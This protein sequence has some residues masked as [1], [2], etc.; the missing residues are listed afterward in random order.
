[1]AK[2]KPCPQRDKEIHSY[3]STRDTGRRRGFVR[4]VRHPAHRVCRGRD[5]D[6]RAAVAAHL[7]PEHVRYTMNAQGRNIDT[8]AQKSQNLGAEAAEALQ[9]G[10]AHTHRWCRRAGPRARGAYCGRGR[11]Q[12]RLLPRLPVVRGRVWVWSE[13]TRGAPHFAAAARHQRRCLGNNAG[14]C[15]WLVEC[16]VL[17]QGIRAGVVVG[18]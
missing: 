8:K 1:M 9:N 2:P 3:G 4:V 6:S 10:G 12:R 17:M 5:L 7:E 16:G 11:H 18:A 14:G 15:V 13:R